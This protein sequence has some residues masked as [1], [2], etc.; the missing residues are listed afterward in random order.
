MWVILNRTEYETIVEISKRP[1]TIGRNP[2]DE[3]KKFAIETLIAFK[4]I[5][6]ADK[7]GLKISPLGIK[8]LAVLQ[9]SKRDFYR[10]MLQIS[11]EARRTI[12]REYQGELN[13]EENERRSRN[14]DNEDL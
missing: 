7:G 11:N 2:K 8:I 3:K 14:A 12:W 1:Y 13:V 5:D 9:G 4:L 6:V 10:T